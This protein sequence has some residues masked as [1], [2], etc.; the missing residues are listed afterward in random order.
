[1]NLQERVAK[2]AEQY[3]NGDDTVI[4]TVMDT[5]PAVA[6]ALHRAL[7]GSDVH[8]ARFFRALEQRVMTA[9]KAEADPDAAKLYIQNK[10]LALVEEA[11]NL[12]IMIEAVE[13]SRDKTGK[14]GNPVNAVVLY[15][16][17]ITGANPHI[18]VN[19]DNDVHGN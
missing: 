17:E 8:A 13:Y 10:L 9:E 12:G 4:D 14:I 5:D 7:H 19:I 3:R 2:L 1:M 6:V 18:V 16:S 15:P 11:N